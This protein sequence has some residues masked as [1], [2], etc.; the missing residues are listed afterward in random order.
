MTLYNITGLASATDV[1]GL[2]TAANTYSGGNL[3]A[4]FTLAMFFIML[5]AFRNRAIEDNIIVSAWLSF[6]IALL[7]SFV[8]LVAFIWVI[9]Y[10]T[11]AALAVLWKVT[12]RRE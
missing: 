3:F 6:T 1:S 5:M 10:L 11:I 7:F 2:F 9:G 8:S 4:M 12:T